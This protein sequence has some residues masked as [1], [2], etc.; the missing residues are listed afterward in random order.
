MMKR[1]MNNLDL[2][3]VKGSLSIS[4]KEFKLGTSGP[5]SSNP[6]FDDEILIEFT[7]TG[8]SY[9]I[10]FLKANYVGATGGKENPVGLVYNEVKE[11]GLRKG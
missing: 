10:D 2:M 6:M 5:W 4:R 7:F 9:T 11:K 3:I 1:A 8:F